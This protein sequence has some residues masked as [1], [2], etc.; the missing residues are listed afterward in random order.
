MLWR[1]TMFKCTV[2]G[3]IHIGDEAPE[4]CPK[5][6]AEKE[7]FEALEDEA[8]GLVERS[9]F[10]NDLHVGLLG[11][12]GEVLAVATDGIE[13]NLDPP[14][15]AIFT[16]AQNDAQELIQSIKAELAGH[17]AKGKWG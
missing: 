3:Y 14:C 6:G 16:R 11:L 2:C 13:D 10:T 15:V 9:A 8:K 17:V 5:C 12:L 1:K 4:K 7:K